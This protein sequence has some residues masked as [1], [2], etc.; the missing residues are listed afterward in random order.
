M[1]KNRV[2]RNWVITGLVGMVVTLVVLGLGVW[3][4]DTAGIIGDQFINGTNL[5]AIAWLPVV[6]SDYWTGFLGEAFLA[7]FGKGGQGL[8]DWS[9]YRLIVDNLIWLVIAV[10]FIVF[11]VV[12][13]VKAIK[14]RSGKHV[15]FAFFFL[16]FAG[17]SVLCTTA[18]YFARHLEWSYESGKLVFEGIVPSVAHNGDLT[19]FH[20]MVNALSFGTANPSHFNGGWQA[21]IVSI[22]A[23][24]LCL[25]AL[26]YIISYLGMAI[27]ALV[28]LREKKEVVEETVPVIETAPQ[29]E[30]APVVE[31]KK[32]IL[33]VKRFDKYGNYGPLVEAGEADYPRQNIKAKPLTVEEVRKV[34]QEEV[35]RAETRRIVEEYKNEKQAEAIAQ[36]IVKASNKE[37]KTSTPTVTQAV[38]GRKE[39]TKIYPSPIIFAMPTS[40]KEEGEKLQ[41]VKEKPVAPKKEKKGLTEDQVKEIIASEIREALKDL[42][43][44][45]ERV[46]EK[47]VEVKVPAKEETHVE[48]KPVVEEAKPVEETPAPETPVETETVVETNPLVETTPIEEEKPVETAEVKETTETV[49]EPVVEEP[50]V[51]ETPAEPVVEETKEETLTTEEVK[52]EEKAEETAPVT[53]EAAPV[54]E[55][56][57]VEETPA[58]ETPVVETPIVTPTEQTEKPKIIRIPFTTRMLE[59][60]DE[61]KAAYNHIK[62]LLKSYGLNNRVANGG[63]S[64]RLHRVTYCKITVAGKSLKLYLALNPQDYVDTTYPIKDAS[65]KNMYKETPLVF[66]VRSGLSLRRADE[67]IRDCMDKHGLE[68]ID[69]VQDHDWASELAN[70]TVEDDGDEG[71]EE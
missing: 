23:Y 62:S 70:V 44:K 39:E 12:I 17:I 3:F 54:N 59:A 24:V 47:Q 66:K 16:I 11:F 26:L 22:L 48:E 33:V 56:P 71:D 69:Q 7:L 35:E 57:V 38:E 21:Y 32:G 5:S 68:Q 28:Q 19:V 43:I 9:N 50:V 20:S 52:E 58:P 42:V 34:I 8:A 53:E 46:V 49:S 60:D 31:K 63:D 30:P 10:L 14:R 15:A 6:S 65:S 37:E 45:H 4:R 2:L 40:V 29:P 1:K 25:A 55:E 41:E 18:Y 27:T 36:A 61:L 13:L 67:L 64:F 51:E